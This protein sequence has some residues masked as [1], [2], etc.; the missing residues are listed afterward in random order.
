MILL[1]PSALN[2]YITE[3]IHISGALM[4]A[5]ALAY[6]RCCFISVGAKQTLEISLFP[7]RLHE[8]LR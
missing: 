2:K 8:P 3:E 4:A 1:G 7:Q 5:L 6:S